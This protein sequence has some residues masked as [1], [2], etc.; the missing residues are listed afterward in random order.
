MRHGILRERCQSHPRRIPGCL[1]VSQLAA[2]LGV[3]PYWIYDRIYNGTIAIERDAKTG[4]YLFPDGP[5]TLR[6]FQKLKA[7]KVD[8]LTSVPRLAC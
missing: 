6:A 2:Q 3:A 5:E 7:G 8:R 1:T 4:L